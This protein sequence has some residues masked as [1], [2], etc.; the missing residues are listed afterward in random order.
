MQTVRHINFNVI[1]LICLTDVA[2]YIYFKKN[3]RNIAQ[4]SFAVDSIHIE[5]N[6]VI[7]DTFRYDLVVTVHL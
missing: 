6:I 1:L 7:L 3:A 4:Y 5:T 2:N